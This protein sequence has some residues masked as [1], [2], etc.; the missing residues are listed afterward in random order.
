M[1]RSED[2]IGTR[3]ERVALEERGESKGAGF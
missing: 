2:R 1:V 3:Q